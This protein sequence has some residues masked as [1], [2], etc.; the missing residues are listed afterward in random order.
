MRS[1]L[2]TV[3]VVLLLVLA[4]GFYFAVIAQDAPKP[5]APAAPA[6]LSPGD[7][8]LAEVAYVS[9]Y[10]QDLKATREQAEQNVSRLRLQI[11][12]LQAE[13][14]KLKKP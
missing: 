5:P 7:Q 12:Q 4:W 9:Q 13:L 3:I 1:L 2:Q 8:C 6:T 11:R 14:E 10:V